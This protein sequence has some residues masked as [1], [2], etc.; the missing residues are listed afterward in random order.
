MTL[1]KLLEQ[2][3]KEVRKNLLAL[4]KIGAINIT[5]KKLKKAFK[6]WDEKKEINN[7]KKEVKKW[8]NKVSKI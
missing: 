3:N 6:I 8:K 2:G 4:S 5:P 1:Q 7:F